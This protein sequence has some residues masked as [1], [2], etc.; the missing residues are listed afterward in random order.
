MSGHRARSCACFRALARRLAGLLVVVLALAGGP[1]AF[2][3]DAVQH[4]A[5]PNPEEVRPGSPDG[6]SP[7]AAVGELKRG[8]ESRRVLGLPVN[9]MLVIAGALLVL[10]VVAGLL[11]PRTRRQAR[12]RGNGTYGG[13]EP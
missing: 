12:A 2:G 4:G 9:A 7:S 3:R 13:P 8:Q 1:A 6:D 11:L 5:Q 10:L